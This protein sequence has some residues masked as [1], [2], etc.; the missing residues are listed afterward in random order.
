MTTATM[1]DGGESRTIAI[2]LWRHFCHCRMSKKGSGRSEWNGYLIRVQL[3]QLRHINS[4]CE[5]NK[6]SLKRREK[7]KLTF[8]TSPASVHVYFASNLQARPSKL[9]TKNHLKWVPPRLDWSMKRNGQ[10]ERKE[11][12]F[13][14]S[15]S[16]HPPARVQ[17]IVCRINKY[18]AHPN[19]MSNRQMQYKS[20][21]KGGIDYCGKSCQSYCNKPKVIVR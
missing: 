18:S 21:I 13:K 10:K 11:E 15:Y 14:F 7:L 1:Q 9:K 3:Q 4:W 17:E 19:C 12:S 6:E 5:G 20:H 8:T 16:T 2:V